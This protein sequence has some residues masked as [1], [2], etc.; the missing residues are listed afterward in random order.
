MRL[1]KARNSLV[2]KSW[3]GITPAPCGWVMVRS[4]FGLMEIFTPG[5]RAT[6]EAPVLMTA[7]Q[8][9]DRVGH[10]SKVSHGWPKVF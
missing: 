4:R 7:R 9:A 1:A 8:I 2:G 3:E 10:W 5:R 6:F